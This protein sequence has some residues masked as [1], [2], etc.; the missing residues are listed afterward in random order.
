MQVKTMRNCQLTKVE[1]GY[2]IQVTDPQSND[3]QQFVAGDLVEVLEIVRLWDE[4]PVKP[5]STKSMGD[6]NDMQEID[7]DG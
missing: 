4:M 1:N 2:L 5:R 7:C 3:R 6:C